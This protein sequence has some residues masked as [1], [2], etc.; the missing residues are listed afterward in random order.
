MFRTA[1]LWAGLA[2][3]TTASLATA[4]PT[5]ADPPPPPPPIDTTQAPAI[6]AMQQ[7]GPAVQQAAA[8]PSSAASL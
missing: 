3:I 7:L 1:N 8:N 6:S 5:W 4:A 2:A